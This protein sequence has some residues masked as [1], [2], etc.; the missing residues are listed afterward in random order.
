MLPEES[1]PFK[2]PKKK[3]EEDGCSALLQ[4]IGGFSPAMMGVARVVDNQTQGPGL[5]AFQAASSW[6]LEASWPK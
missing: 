6:D 3:K 4:S 5:R 1:D 2:T